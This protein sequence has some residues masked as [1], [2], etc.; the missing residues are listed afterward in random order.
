MELSTICM[1]FDST[2]RC[3]GTHLYTYHILNGELGAADGVG[4]VFDSHVRRNNIQRMRSVFLNQ[5]GSLCIR[6]CGTV[7]KLGAYVPP[8]EPGMCVTL[9]IDLDGLNAQFA[10]YT[11]QGVLATADVSFD[12]LFD[13]TLQVALRS[14]FFCAVVTKEISVCLL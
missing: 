6:D 2:I 12:G 4:F 1:I 9:Q 7:R 8:L 13:P 11:A 5:R 14:G 10:T 3:G